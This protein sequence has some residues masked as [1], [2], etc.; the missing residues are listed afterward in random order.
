M[1][2]Q[3]NPQEIMNKLAK[4]QEDVDFIKDNIVDID[5]ILTEDD[6]KALTLSEKE[7]EEG[8]LVSLEEIERERK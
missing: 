2:M 6:R 3:I 1:E 4:L 5:C 8:K 7:F